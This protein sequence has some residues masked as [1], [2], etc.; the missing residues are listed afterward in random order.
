MEPMKHGNA[1]KT[2]M[3]LFGSPHKRGFTG[4]LLEEYLKA[5][6]DHFHTEM[7][8]AYELR[9]EPCQGCRYC[10]K[11]EGCP[12]RDFD[13]IDQLLRTV[14][15]LLVATPIYYLGM[16]A[17]LKAIFD[18]TQRYFSA[19]FSRR[20]RPPIAKHKE[21]VL[22]LTCGAESGDGAEIVSRQIKMAFTV[23][24]ATLREEILWA[25]TDTNQ[26]VS[27]LLPEIREA[28]KKMQDRLPI[29][30]I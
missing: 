7:V 3:V 23:L 20:L 17:P 11:Q 15:L 14:D 19:R 18:R 12:I 10:E 29:L 6:G 5:L 4:R 25:G 16:P 27:F 30:A 2:A 26:D 28:A 13:E 24:N 9:V 21:A 1:K 8:N 22:L